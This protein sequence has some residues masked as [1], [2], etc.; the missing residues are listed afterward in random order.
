MPGQKGRYPRHLAH[1]RRPIAVF[2]QTLEIV[3]V[4]KKA[5][6]TLRRKRSP[7]RGEELYQVWPDDHPAYL[8]EPPWLPSNEF[9]FAVRIAIFA[10]F[11]L[12]G[13][14]DKFEFSQKEWDEYFEN[15]KRRALSDPEDYADWGSY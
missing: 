5:M 14:E 13:G 3:Y 8:Q 9:C 1:P 6:V 15:A 11:V 7:T 4:E 2:D 10:A 12:M